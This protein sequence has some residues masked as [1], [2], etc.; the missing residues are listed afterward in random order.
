MV[1]A[2]NDIDILA[3]CNSYDIG[4]ILPNLLAIDLG[5]TNLKFFLLNINED[6]IRSIYSAYVRIPLE[7]PSQ[8]IYEH[9]PNL[10]KKYLIEYLTSIVKRFRIDAISISSYLFGTLI[11]DEHGNTIT[12]IITWEDERAVEVL[13]MLEK[14]SREIYARTG[15]PVLHMYS[16]PKLLFLKIRMGIPLKN[17]RVLDSKSFLM[18]ILSNEYVSDLSTASGT[19]QLLNIHRLRWDDFMLSLLDVDESILPNIMEGDKLIDLDPRISREIGLD[20]HIPIVLGL[21]DGGIMCLG[22]TIGSMEKAVIN[23]GTSAMLRV[24]MDKPIID[25]PELQRL[26]TYYLVD[27]LWIPGGSINNAGIVIDWLLDNVFRDIGYGDD[28]YYKLFSN[29][30]DT[31]TDVIFIPLLMPER[32]RAIH[33]MYSGCILGID[34][35]KSRLDIAKALVNGII[36]LLKIFDDILTENGLRYS[37]VIAGGSLAKISIVP[38]LIS[39]I[40]GKIVKIPIAIDLAQLGHAVLYMHAVYGKSFSVIRDIVSNQLG[41][42]IYRP[43]DYAYFHGKYEEFKK[44][45]QML[46]GFR[47]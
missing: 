47:V 44:V 38:Q 32:I 35:E 43:R 3:L 26:Q 10:I 6:S 25:E 7:R 15:C 31:K 42:S 24:L 5:T 37:E 45:L 39:D 27:G 17:I 29:I 40:F 28:R 22:A 11:V 13:P 4:G 46:Q 18:H 12:N 20:R 23:M 33:S 16:L 41:Y 19:Y 14:Y 36:M 34:R 2:N 1:N 8:N 9:N 30:S 21:Y